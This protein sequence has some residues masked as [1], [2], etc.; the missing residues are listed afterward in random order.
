MALLS[1]FSES[2]GGLDVTPVGTMELVAPL[3]SASTAA[4]L[5]TSRRSRSRER[6]WDRRYSRYNVMDAGI[7]GLPSNCLPRVFGKGPDAL[8]AK[9]E[10]GSADAE[11]SPKT[12]AA[13]ASPPCPCSADSMISSS[14]CSEDIVLVQYKCAI[15]DLIWTWNQFY[16]VFV[17]VV[18]VCQR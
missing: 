4:T 1:E 13:V 10:A 11:P 9:T 2:P 8:P 7:A 17:F 18:A 6:E 15:Q 12:E 16:N 3:D 14:S 5:A